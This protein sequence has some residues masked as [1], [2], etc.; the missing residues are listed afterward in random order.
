MRWF[1]EAWLVSRTGLLRNLVS[2]FSEV[3]VGWGQYFQAVIRPV[4]LT[5]LVFGLFVSAA[6]VSLVYGLLN[7][8]A[9]A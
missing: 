8:C 3:Q 5:C 7:G 4:L 9:G 6:A 2:P 1:V